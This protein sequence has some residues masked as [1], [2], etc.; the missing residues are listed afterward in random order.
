MRSISF[1]PVSRRHFFMT[2][3]G[4]TGA[5]AM[6]GTKNSLGLNNH[7]EKNVRLA[8]LADTHIAA[9]IRDNYREFYPYQ[10]LQKIIPDIL[11][12]SPDAAVVAGDLA[13]LT[14][15]SG[16]YENLKIL[17]NPILEKIPVFMATGNHDDRKNFL[18]SF[19][20]LPGKKQ[21]VE[22]K[23]VIIADLPPVRLIILDSLLYVNGYGAEGLLGKVQRAWLQNYLEKSDDKPTILF[24][25]H[26]LTDQDNSL[27]DAPRLFEII[28][29]QTKVKAVIHGHTHLYGF[30]EHQ[31]IHL[32][33][34]PPTSYNIFSMDD[35]VGWVEAQLTA[36][37]GVFTLHI[38]AG[39]KEKDR[40]VTQLKWRM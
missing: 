36:N 5:L 6:L 24:L 39:N 22:N 13:R 19:D 17:L 37:G 15:E 26:Q 2:S 29:K 25:H 20:T 28:E 11:T 3:L 1:K 30:S 12:I 16:D 40:C 33:N 21:A 35:P 4:V 14:G 18:Q 7:E 8:L 10:N 9:D 31:G 23:H 34:L 38:A 27:L 32:I